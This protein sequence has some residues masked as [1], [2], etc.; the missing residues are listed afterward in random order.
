MP[1]FLPW[2]F[3][4]GVDGGRPLQAAFRGQRRPRLAVGRLHHRGAV[5]QGAIGVGHVRVRTVHV[6]AAAR[7]V[8]GPHR[9]IVVA[10]AAAVVSRALQRG[11]VD[12]GGGGSYGGKVGTEDIA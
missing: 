8:A 9:G 12:T 4:N 6:S 5:L 2:V 10:P 3:L 1:F 7:G 11:G